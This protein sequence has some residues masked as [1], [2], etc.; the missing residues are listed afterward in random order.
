MCTQLVKDSDHIS[1][2]TSIDCKVIHSNSQD[3]QSY[4]ALFPRVVMLVGYSPR[5]SYCDKVSIHIHY[6]FKTLA[7]F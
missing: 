7:I 1:G 4:F 2:L 5:F 6:I 3:M